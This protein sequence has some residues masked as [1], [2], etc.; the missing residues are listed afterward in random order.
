[1][2]TTSAERL[3][4][5]AMICAPNEVEIRYRENQAAILIRKPE[6]GKLNDMRP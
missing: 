6:F 4:E 5:T 2:G 1:M 3:F